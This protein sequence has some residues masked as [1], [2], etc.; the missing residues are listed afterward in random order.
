MKYTAFYVDK[1]LCLDVEGSTAE[2]KAALDGCAKELALV[3]DERDGDAHGL[4]IKDFDPVKRAKLYYNMDLH[5]PDCTL[6]SGSTFEFQAR[7][8]ALEQITKKNAEGKDENDEPSPPPPG[9]KA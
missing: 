1:E 9:Y 6:P 7:K 4:F 8:H 3:V 5:A 2:E